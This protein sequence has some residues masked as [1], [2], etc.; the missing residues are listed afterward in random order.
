MEEEEKKK[1]EKLYLVDLI[2]FSLN[3]LEMI[4]RIRDSGRPLCGS[5]DV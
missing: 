5:C 3:H 2:H 1:K 4:L